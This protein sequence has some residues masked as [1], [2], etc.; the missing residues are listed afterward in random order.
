M[1]ELEPLHL[2]A[3]EL[4]GERLA[5]LADELDAYLEAEVNHPLDHRLAR[6]PVRLER[7]LDVVRS[8]ERAVHPVRLPDEGHD[9]LVCRTLVQ[10][11]RA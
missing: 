6:R 11:A 7:Q 10:L 8:H 9:E 1:L 5:V 2:V 4:N 3:G